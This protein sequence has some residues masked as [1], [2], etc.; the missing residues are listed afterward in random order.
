MDLIDFLGIKD[1]LFINELKNETLNDLP[2]RYRH[3]SRVVEG[4]YLTVCCALRIR[5][6]VGHRQLMLSGNILAVLQ[7]LKD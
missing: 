7:S 5:I 3:S 1:I 2:S 4:K 6:D